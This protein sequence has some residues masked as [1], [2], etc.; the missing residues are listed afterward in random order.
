MRCIIALLVSLTLTAYS[1]AQVSEPDADLEFA[2][3]RDEYIVRYKPLVLADS[4]AWWEANISGSDEAFAREKEASKKLVDVHSDRNVFARLKTLKDQGRVRDP[5]LRREL[6]EMY[7]AFL[8]GQA[9]PALQ[10][11]IVD[12]EADVEQIFNTH[13]GVVGGQSLTENDVRD[14]LTRSTDTTEVEATWKAYMEVGRKADPKLREL[15]R[16]RNAVATQLGFKNYF[17]MRLALQEIDEAELLKLF[18]ELDDLTRAPFAQLKTEIDAARA[19]RFHVAPAE[20]RPWHFND[21]F[22]QEAPGNKDVDFDALFK[23]ADLLAL[24]RTY[25][26]SIGLPVDDI[27][28]RSDLYEKPGKCPHAYCSDLDRAGDIRVLANLKPNVYW[29]GTLLHEVGHGV[30]DKYIR[31][32]VPFLLHGASSGITTEGMALLFGALVKNEDWLTRVLKVEPARAEQIGRAARD[33]LRAEELMFCRWAQVMVRFEQGLYGD[34]QQDLGKLW[35]DLKKRY[36]L[37]NP[38]ETT[39]RP[40]YAAKTHILS[41]PVYYQSYMLGELFAAQ[42]RDYLVRNVMRGGDARSTSFYEHPEVGAYLR[43]QVFGPGKLYSWSALTRRATGEPLSAK[44]FA[45]QFVH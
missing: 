16:L 32:D 28:A 17:S 27:L 20:L 2:S 41:S 34:P 22:F 35:W 26:A 12:L 40:D 31:A 29:A 18:D 6:D 7:R 13:R 38:P 36:Q 14:I 21:L 9:D 24:T 37:L 39:D 1:P 25:Y 15:V 23:D 3:L 45:E 19:A 4:A 8:P 44:C 11:Q 5:V 33:M 30:Y 43:E 42:V 10:K